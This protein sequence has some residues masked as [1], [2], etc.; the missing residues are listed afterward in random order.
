MSQISSI[1]IH[2]GHHM[3]LYEYDIIYDLIYDVIE[4][5]DINSSLKLDIE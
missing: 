5:S 2:L 3:I 4:M 1:G